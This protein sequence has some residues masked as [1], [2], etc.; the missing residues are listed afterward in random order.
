MAE[1]NLDQQ[2]ADGINSHLQTLQKGLAFQPESEIYSA[3]AKGFVELLSVAE[4]MLFAPFDY[5]YEV[6]A[7]VTE[8]VLTPVCDEL[9]MLNE[10]IDRGTGYQVSALSDLMIFNVNAM[11]EYLGI[12][13]VQSA[14]AL[15]AAVLAAGSIG[16]AADTPQLQMISDS[17]LAELEY[18]DRED[19]RIPKCS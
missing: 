3:K 1:W 8:P 7:R 9:Q 17:T 18:L 12:T 4:D 13:E 11:A 16:P 5:L 2:T 6:T 10:A 14:E 15:Q 19:E